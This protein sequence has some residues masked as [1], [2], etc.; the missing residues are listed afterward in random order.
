MLKQIA[1]IIIIIPFVL[2]AQFTIYTPQNSILTEN[3]ANDIII[4]FDNRVW[5]ISNLDVFVIENGNW[6]IF[7]SSNSNLP[8]QDGRRLYLDNNGEVW[9]LFENAIAKYN[10]GEFLIVDST[11]GGYTFA[12]DY[13]QNIWLSRNDELFV[14]RNG[15]WEKAL[16]TGLTPKLGIYEILVD[17]NNNIWFDRPENGFRKVEGDS[18]K[19]IINPELPFDEQDYLRIKLDSNSNIWASSIGDVVEY[20]PINESWLSHKSKFQNSIFSK[21]HNISLAFDKNNH[22]YVGS[23][24]EPEGISLVL[25]YSLIN[26][27]SQSYFVED[28]NDENIEPIIPRSI[29]ALATDFDGNVW[30]CALYKG[31][32]KFDSKLLSVPQLPNSDYSIYPNPTTDQLNIELENEL[33]A[34]RYRITDTKVKQVLTGSFSPSSSVS[35]NVEQLP[36]GVYIIEITTNSGEIVIDKF[37]KRK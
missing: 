36:S 7:N 37:V 3:G 14:K 26:D 17:K 5:I 31:I 20:N 15:K 30:F 2:S 19:L 25:F 12:V 28:D 18:S 8:N 29:R 34:T 21:S 11:M 9:L 10:N 32:G 27:I 4:D 23:I 13:N 22:C 6:N 35:I 33:L 1:L 24:L 16:R